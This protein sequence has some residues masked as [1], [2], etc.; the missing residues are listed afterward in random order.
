MDQVLSIYVGEMGVSFWENVVIDFDGAR[1]STEEDFGISYTRSMDIET[2]LDIMAGH[3]YRSMFG[4]YA[5]I[6][7][8]DL[9][10]LLVS[11][12]KD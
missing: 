6:E 7:D 3:G 5:I 9:I 10:N 4:K 2:F 8:E 12:F 11:E 1:Y